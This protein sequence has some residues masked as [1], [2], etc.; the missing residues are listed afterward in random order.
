MA[1]TSMDYEDVSISR[2]GGVKKQIIA[3]A[4]EDALGPPPDGTVVTAHYTGTLEDG[5]KF[6]SSVDRGSPFTFTIGEGQVIRGWDEG[7][8]S[9]KVGEKAK[10]LIRSDYGYGKNGS[11]PKIPKDA[12]LI[13]E[14]ELLGFEEKEK[15]KYDYSDEERREKATS[16]KGEGTILFKESKFGEAAEKYKQAADWAFDDEEGEFVPDDDKPLYVS[17]MNNAAMCYLKVNKWSEVIKLSTSVLNV[18]G[19]SENVKALY[20]RGLARLKSNDL[21]AAKSDLMAAFK[22]DANKDVRKALAQLKV[23]IADGKKKEKAIYGGIFGKVSMYDDKSNILDLNS[24]DDP[25]VFF[26]VSHGVEEMGR[27]VM[28]L[29]K[30][31]VPKTAENF[32]ALCTGEKKVGSK[33]VPLH[34]KGCK[35]HRVIKDFMIQGGDFTAGDG[36]GGES[37]YG[38]K[39]AD[40]N[41]KIKH[42]EGGLL[43]MANA[44]PG[45]NGS[46]F[47]ITS[48]ETPHLDN[49]HVIFGRV[50][51]GMDIVRKIENVEKGDNDKPIVDV[52]ITECGEMPKDMED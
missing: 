46:Q 1:E 34:Y 18:E 2:D 37:I 26:D 11:P 48:R 24:P 8:A 45:T 49:K 22:I 42:T 9:M 50:I 21:Q 10:L 30:S 35:F 6:D 41:F 19:E 4:P 12:T 39:F 51:E 47:F 29:F 17:C 32:R 52:V 33:G 16:L 27:I 38:E 14:V 43:S 5:T 44:G 36:T 23:A 3:A 13:F 28:K 20:R 15:E 40:E 25:C 31:V 7:F